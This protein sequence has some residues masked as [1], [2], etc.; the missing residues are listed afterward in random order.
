LLSSWANAR[1]RC[2]ARQSADHGGAR[3]LFAERLSGSAAVVFDEVVSEF[4]RVVLLDPVAACSAVSCGNA[5]DGIA[6][7]EGAHEHLLRPLQPPEEVFPCA[8]CHP[9][10]AACNSG[11]L[12]YR[13]VLF[14]YGDQCPGIPG[15]GFLYNH[16][17][18]FLVRFLLS[19]GL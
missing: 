16:H 2:K 11:N 13:E 10:T 19:S 9:G 17:N 7:V 14:S 12:V 8:D 15:S 4:F 18:S 3:L 1:I 5:V 6:R